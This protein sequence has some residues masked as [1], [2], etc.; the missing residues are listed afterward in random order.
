MRYHILLCILSASSVLG[1]RVD[2]RCLEEG[3][4]VIGDEVFAADGFEVDNNETDLL[5]GEDFGWDDL[6]SFGFEED[7]ATNLRGSRQ[8]QQFANSSLTYS[9]I[10]RNLQ[11]GRTFNLKLTWKRGACWQGA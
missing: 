4:L 7:E 3:H 10:T 11:S 9:N 5:T 6:A 2:R 1:W 8:G